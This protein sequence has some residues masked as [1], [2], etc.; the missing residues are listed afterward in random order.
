MKFVGIAVT[1]L[2]ILRI[3]LSFVILRRNIKHQLEGKG[4]ENCD[5]CGKCRRG[6]CRK[7]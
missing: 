5:R 2:C 1:I 7:V 4:C 3:I 6:I